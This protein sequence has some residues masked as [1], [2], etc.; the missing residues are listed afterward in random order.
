MSRLC[1]QSETMKKLI[2]LFVFCALALEGFSQKTKEILYVGTY[3]VRGSEGIYVYEF[4]RPAGTFQ[5]IQSIKTL[6]SPTYLT[7]HPSRKYLYSVNRG[8]LPGQTRPGSVSAYSIS[9]ET[10]KLTLLNHHSSYGDGPCYI[11]TDRTGKMVFITN[12][13]EGNLVVLKV[14]DNGSLTTCSDSIRFS[15]KSIH[16]ERQ[17]KPH[18]HC[19]MP[20]PDNK[21][22][23]VTDL[24]SDRIFSFAIDHTLAKLAPAQKPYVEVRRG[25]G[26]RHFTFHPNGQFIYVTEELTST[27]AWLSYEKETGAL[28]LKQDEITS[29]PVDFSG[30]NSSADIHTDLKG[31]YLMMSN[32]G[33]N[34]VSTYSIDKN[35]A[36]TWLRS[37]NTGGDKPR[38]F[39]V[40]KQ[41]QFVF[42][43]HQDTD[44]IVV[45][46]WNGKKG[47]LTPADFQIKVPSPVCLKM[48]SLKQ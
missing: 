27:V 9:A 31:K 5:L 44:N 39:L 29:L 33:H 43:A 18:I 24:G 3:S 23:I 35:G 20:S 13:N 15:G 34:A 25:A 36:L 26:P 40:D 46:R 38:N 8:P 16:P 6:E 32:R 12:Y 42:V 1:L 7:I 19:A 10:G 47:M 41:N 30:V 14:S 45:F 28:S 48:I 21:Y 11:S 37:E 22:L 17:T 4:D 2:V